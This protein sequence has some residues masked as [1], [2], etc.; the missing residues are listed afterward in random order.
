[1]AFITGLHVS[2]NF[3]EKK[4]LESKGF[5]QITKNLNEGIAG[6][7]SIYLWYKKG[8]TA[9][10]TRVQVSFNEEMAVKL[11]GYHKIDKNLNTGTS[12]KP[13][14]MWFS[15]TTGDYDVPITDIVVTVD[16][17]SEVAQLTTSDLNLGTR[18]KFVYAWLKRE[19]PIYICDVTAT[20]TYG[21]DLSLFSKGYTRVDVN[22]NMGTRGGAE[23]F[24]WYRKTINKE[25]SLVALDVSI[26]QEQAEKLKQLNYN[27]VGVNLNEN[28]SGS[29]VYL[30]FQTKPKLDRVRGLV[31]LRNSDAV[32]VY[33]RGRVTVV[34]R[35]LNAGNHGDI[36]YMCFV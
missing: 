20:A 33:K 10:I 35:S 8:D 14:Y 2:I 1:M 28:T 6:A 15:K 30:W 26:N 3:D 23:V 19:R 17:N 12:G 18:G 16:P 24:I 22:T 32:E 5:Q 4:L 36:I 31:L 9:P 11:T 21:Q 13:L 25:L 7:N 27:M 34:E 29:D